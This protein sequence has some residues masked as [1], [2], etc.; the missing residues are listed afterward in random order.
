MSS[1]L[2]MALGRCV[3]TDGF[4]LGLCF[5]KRRICV[6]NFSEGSVKDYVG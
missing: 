4:R 5:V 3:I 6:L 2:D 1:G